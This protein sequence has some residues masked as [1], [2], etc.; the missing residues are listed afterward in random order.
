ML[1]EMKLVLYISYILNT[2]SSIDSND[3][4]VAQKF[5]RSVVV[6]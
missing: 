4:F 2:N 1:I 3:N 6:S 5:L